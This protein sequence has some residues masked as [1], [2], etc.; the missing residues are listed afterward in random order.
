M[1]PTQLFSWFLLCGCLAFFVAGARAQQSTRTPG[2][3][4]AVKVHGAVTAKSGDGTVRTLADNNTLTQDSTVTTAAGSSVILIFS[5]GATLNLGPDSELVIEQFL[6]DPFGDQIKVADM[7]EEPTTSQTT[8]SLTRGELV[9]DV[10]H[11]KKDRGSEFTVKTPVGAA[12]IRGTQFRIVFKPDASGKVFFT[13]ATAEGEVL[14]QGEAA[15]GVS[16]PKDQ[17][18]SVTID[19]TVDTATGKI[20][21]NTPPAVTTTQE[22]S[23]DNKAAITTAVSDIVTQSSQAIIDS[24]KAA[25][26]KAAAEKAA[27]D[28]AAADKA[29]A[30]KAAADKAAADKAAADKAAADK[31]AA[32]KAAADKAAADKAAADKAAADKAAADKAAQDQ[33]NKQDANPPANTPSSDTTPGDGATV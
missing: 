26:E 28:K 3:I 13:L 16:V 27:A 10:K 2:H 6:Q 20:T 11:L 22:I 23:G 32:D 14:F 29:A 5:N 17:E 33:Q 12:G 31:A 18:V 15:A 25:E 1:R 24:T 19:A 8:L 30:D 4:L 7:Q 9:G 21:V